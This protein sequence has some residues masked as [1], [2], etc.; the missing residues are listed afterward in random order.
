MGAHLTRGCRATELFW[1]GQERLPGQEVEFPLHP[2]VC[3]HLP[4]L[5]PWPAGR[6]QSHG[7]LRV[8]ACMS[9]FVALSGLGVSSPPWYSMGWRLGLPALLLM[10]M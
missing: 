1:E 4:V 7:C 5:P 10:A 2:E 6:G 9:W 3:S 8:G